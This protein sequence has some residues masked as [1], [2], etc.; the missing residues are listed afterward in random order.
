MTLRFFADTISDSMLGEILATISVLLSS[1][2][3][4]IVKSTLGFIKL[5]IHSLPY[6]LVRE[7][8]PH[9]VPALLN[10]SHD[11]KNH[12]KTKVRHI[13]ERTIRR[14]GYEEVISHV[15]KDKDDGK[16]VLQNIKK[17]KDRAKRKKA[18]AGAGDDESEGEG[19]GKRDAK[20][21]GDA[22]EDVLYGSESEL[23]DS[24]DEVAPAPVTKGKRKGGGYQLRDDA[25]DPMDL[26]DGAA[27]ALTS[28]CRSLRFHTIL[29][30]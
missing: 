14:F 8:L 24:E 5:A 10:W 23:E 9:L 18:A 20:K 22:F 15:D 3:R 30:A 2:N 25:D 29:M 26:L 27:S 17:R 7:A 1:A 4:E 28:E 16:K 19:A 12:F 13:F 21:S 6:E 11:H